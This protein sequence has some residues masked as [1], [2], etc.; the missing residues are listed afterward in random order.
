MFSCTRCLFVAL[1]FWGAV[2]LWQRP[3]EKQLLPLL[4]G[5]DGRPLVV[6]HQLVERG[7]LS[8]ADAVHV[9]LH[10]DTEVLVPAGRLQ[11]HRK[12]AD[13]QKQKKHDEKI[14]LDRVI[15]A[16]EKLAGI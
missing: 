8:L 14:L 12:V 13:L 3:D 2:S 9:A 10:V 1:F 11:R 4:A 5:V 7:E 15:M 6:L 16:M